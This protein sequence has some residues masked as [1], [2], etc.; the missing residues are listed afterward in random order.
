MNTHQNIEISN[1]QDFCMINEEHIQIIAS[2]IL[3][4]ARRSIQDIIVSLSFVSDEEIRE[5]NK[6]YLSRDY[7]T[8]VISFPMEDDTPSLEHPDT[9]GD[10]IISVERAFDNARTFK[11]TP[12]HELK[13]Y[14][15]HGIL[16]LLGYN[17]TEPDEKARMQEKENLYIELLKDMDPIK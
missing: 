2:N 17:D 9:L 1:R 11:T 12:S 15:I 3:S 14:I 4:S 5:I 10:I 16:H 8:D 6:H 13:L 7:F